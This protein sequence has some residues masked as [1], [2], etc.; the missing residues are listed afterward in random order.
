VL[1]IVLKS[2][3]EIKIPFASF[4]K[5]FI[6]TFPHPIKAE[7][8]KKDLFIASGDFNSDPLNTR[9]MK[10]LR[11]LYEHFTDTQVRM[12]KASEKF[13]SKKTSDTKANVKL[14]SE[15]AKRYKIYGGNWLLFFN[16]LR[17]Y[18]WE[19]VFNF[20]LLSALK[21]ENW[22]IICRF[23][24]KI[25]CADQII[26]SFG[27]EYSYASVVDEVEH[28][29]EQSSSSKPPLDFDKG[30]NDVL[31][32]IEQIYRPDILGLM[33]VKYKT[34]I[35]SACCIQRGN[36]IRPTVYRDQF[37]TYSRTFRPHNYDILL[38]HNERDD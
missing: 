28:F 23:N 8:T 3:A 26:V 7:Y 16:R 4:V 5:L 18:N 21:R 1:N 2:E 19:E 22:G 34:D 10:N 17:M 30:V 29:P 33:D 38:E 9:D 32:I 35:M 37:S 24:V 25:S 20:L 31:K 12:K 13:E 15:L 27:N 11:H 14:I 36:V 6:E